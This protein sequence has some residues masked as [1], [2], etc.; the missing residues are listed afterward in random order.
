MAVDFREVGREG[1]G[2]IKESEP[3][4]NGESILSRTMLTACDGPSIARG[5]SEKRE[6]RWFAGEGK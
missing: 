4:W 1:N 3:K 5:M 6:W 2:R